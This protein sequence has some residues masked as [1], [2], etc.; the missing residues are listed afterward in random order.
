[1]AKN[2]TITV[3]QQGHEDKVYCGPRCY[4]MDREPKHRS[5][6]L[7]RMMKDFDLKEIWPIVGEAW[8]DPETCRCDLSNWS[9]I[10]CNPEGDRSLAMNEQERAHL[11]AM[12]E[13]FD[14]WQCGE[15]VGFGEELA[16]TDDRAKAYWHACRIA[17]IEEPQ[18]VIAA[19]LNRPKVLAF[20]N[21][22]GRSEYVVL[23]SDLRI[24]SEKKIRVIPVD[25]YLVGSEHKVHSD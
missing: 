17:T 21:R 19:Q 20:F 23:R 11:A 3:T 22:D 9:A 13:W 16:W 1:M 15:N 8:C 10:W 12:P 2:K 14:V 6:A 25:D 24:I 4:V 7:L 5:K 18:R